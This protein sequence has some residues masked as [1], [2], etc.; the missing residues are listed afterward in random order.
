M[1]CMKNFL[2]AWLGKHHK[3]SPDYQV[4][5]LETG[6]NQRF[7]CELR[8]Q[9]FDYV[10]IGNSTSKKSAMENSA[11][12]FCEYLVREG[13]M[14][15]DLLDGRSSNVH[16]RK[17]TAQCA[18]LL[19]LPPTEQPVPYIRGP[20]ESYLKA[21]GQANILEEQEQF[22]QN[23]EI[24][25]NWT[26]DNAKARL[27]EYVQSSFKGRKNANEYKYT[28]TGPD[29]Q[30]SFIAQMSVFVK[31]INREIHA[32][33]HGSSKQQ[34]SKAVALSLVRQ[35]YHLKLIEP[36]SGQRKK[37]EKTTVPFEVKVDQPILEAID[38]VVVKEMCPV[39]DTSKSTYP[40]SLIPEQ[41]LGIFT[42]VKEFKRMQYI[43][44]TP[45][46]PNWNPWTACNIDDAFHLQANL[47]LISEGLSNQYRN[48]HLPP[49]LPISA[50]R[51]LIVDSVDRNIG[52]ALEPRT[53]LDKVTI[54]RGS[55][56]CGKTTQVPQ[57]ILDSYIESGHG[58]E[59]NIV[60][61]QPRRICAVSVSER[62]AAERGEDLGVSCGYCVRFDKLLPR[63]YG[64]I[65]FCTVGLLL[66]KLE[67]GLRG[68]SHIVV[69]EI[70]ER[71]C[72]TDFL[73]VII[74]D[75]LKTCNGLHVILMSATVDTTLF[76]EYFDNCS[77]I[78]VPGKVYG[79]KEY[80]LED[81]IEMTGFNPLSKSLNSNR[82]QCNNEDV[83]KLTDGECDLDCNKICEGNY[84]NE[85][86]VSMSMLSEKA[87]P[88]DVIEALL[89]HIVTLPT[90]GGSVLVFLP[91]WAQINSLC[92]MLQVHPIFG[93]ERFRILPLHSQLMRSEQHLVFQQ[94]PPGV[95]KIIVSTNIAESSITINDV[96]YVIDSCKVKQK[97]F[98]SHNQLT[99]Y[100]VVW[101]SKSNLKQR[102][103][104]AGR[105]CPGL[106]F[107]L[108]SRARF[109]RLDEYLTPEIFRTPLHEL[110]LSI[111]L[112][113][114]GN[115]RAFLQRAIEPPPMSAVA[116]AEF[117]LVQMNAL[118]CDF[119][120]TQLGLIIARLPLE[121]KMAKI[122]VIACILQLG[123]AMCAIAAAL[124]FS[125]PYLHDAPHLRWTHIK[126]SGNRFSD[127]VAL[128]N[129]FQQYER[130]LFISEQRAIE[131]C[132]KNALNAALMSMIFEARNQLKQIMIASGFR[133]EN[134][135]SQWYDVNGSD[136]K[137]DLITSL[138]SH[139]LY[140][141]V[142]FHL[143]KRKL[144]TTGGKHALLTKL[145]VN[146]T[147]DDVKFPSPFFVYG[148]KVKTKAVS[149]KQLTMI[150]PIQLLL[151]GNGKIEAT[152]PSTVNVDDWI[153]LHVDVD[154]AAKIVTTK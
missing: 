38:N 33:E 54:I 134:L 24:H 98:T 145:S 111:R 15:P 107:R 94:V 150:T 40:F 59:C 104:R 153:V 79:V 71:D 1:E 109:D 47:Q 110:I 116:E 53:V 130:A 35:L 73:L 50:L 89:C 100:A 97:I 66:R 142:C 14:D 26:L 27:N 37:K 114:L 57:F 60:V 55:T 36:Y 140:P 64:S 82:L 45:P 4:A 52:T 11:R 84:S 31:E 139:G 112:L 74:K 123:D 49:V 10:A 96:V 43:P 103:G 133:E 108:V 86:R 29:N 63:A 78:E 148:E 154:I 18:P 132:E 46:I 121:P 32:K 34:A 7:K 30:K 115:A 23:S 129:C 56:G 137:L 119:E 72:N 20:P 9:T 106:C 141:N 146:Y 65:L 101:A 151:C 69:D 6:T 102:A 135:R 99:N 85:T 58:A 22:D 92:K 93:T 118:T 44:W 67:S 83:G 77:V 75:M 91:G 88:F 95:T 128:L 16:V 81:I 19:P 147:P 41:K 124:S 28:S 125:E 76:S 12:D 5:Q 127:H 144:L 149:V 105:V 80:F 3:L 138:L 8:V 48:R 122:L 131:L 152:D 120:L 113:R 51:A 143:S 87:V 25:G 90:D 68:V 126:L 62:I 2:Y 117:G 21:I 39:V 42:P 17:P 61:T 136:F 13:K 70:H